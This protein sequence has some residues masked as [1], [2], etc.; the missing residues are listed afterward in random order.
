MAF[1][2]GAFD[3][4]S[5]IFINELGA[6]PGLKFIAEKSVPANFPDSPTA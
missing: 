6:A 5:P 3:D 1:D 2:D 4:G